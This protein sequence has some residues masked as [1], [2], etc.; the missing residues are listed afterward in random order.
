MITFL[1]F[2]TVI[3]HYRYNSDNNKVFELFYNV[4][5]KNFVFLFDYDPRIDSISIIRYKFEQFKKSV[6]ESTSYR[7]KI[8][9]VFNLILTPGAAFNDD[10]SR[11]YI[12]RKNKT[13][14]LSLPIFTD[15]NYDSIALD[16]NHLLYKRHVSVVFTSFEKVIETSSLDFCLK[17]INN[18]RISLTVDL[19]YLFSPDKQHFFK[20]LLVSN[21]NI[22]PDISSDIFNY[23]GL[24]A[25]ADNVLEK[26]GKK[27][28]YKLC[29]QINH[30]SLVLL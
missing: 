4:G 16:I 18:P 22:L 28:Y 13:L 27:S 26:Y 17:F 5:I 15:K 29:S 10:I 9:C 23:A 8:K 14:F 19:N 30:S 25:S 20:S 3:L 11:L 6:L 24:I 2:D 1:G 7:V 21:S 12:N